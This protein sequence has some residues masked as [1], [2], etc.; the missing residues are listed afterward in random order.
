VF[1]VL[2]KKLDRVGMKLSTQWSLAMTPRRNLE[3]KFR[4]RDLDAVRAALP[5]LPTRREGVQLQTDTYFH[6][7]A[8]RLKLREIDGQPAMLI[9]Y[10]RSD[11][12]TA[13]LCNYHLIPIGEPALLCT[14]LTAALGERGVV[15]K[16]REIYLYRN[17]RIHLDEVEGLGT[18]VEFEAVLSPHDDETAAHADL[19]MLQRALGLTDAEELAVSN[20]DLLRE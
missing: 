19:E 9:W 5:S 20:V 10:N 7:R 13:K 4:C 14:A 15:R 12:A 6:A 2:S 11:A 18:F 16:R 8:G 17:V 3:S 1:S